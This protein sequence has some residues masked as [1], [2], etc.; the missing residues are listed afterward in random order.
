MGTSSHGAKIRA[1][2]PAVTAGIR[3]VGTALSCTRGMTGGGADHL[4]ALDDPGNDHYTELILQPVNAESHFS[5]SSQEKVP[6]S[7]PSQA[8]ASDIPAG[9]RRGTIHASRFSHKI[10]GTETPRSFPARWNE[11]SLSQAPLLARP[12]LPQLHFAAQV[13]EGSPGHVVAVPVRRASLRD[14]VLGSHLQ[15]GLGKVPAPGHQVADQHAGLFL[16]TQGK[17][18]GQWGS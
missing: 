18:R 10:S 7:L 8:F 17:H 14:Q 2:N 6:C 16:G 15:D 1:G 5:R 3:A 12:Q 9:R 4:Q 13:P 11:D